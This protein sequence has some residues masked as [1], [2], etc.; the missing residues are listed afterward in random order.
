[1]IP[2]SFK[3][4]GFILLFSTALCNKLSAQSRV[5]KRDSLVLKISRGSGEYAGHRIDTVLKDQ[6]VVLYNDISCQ[7]CLRGG[8]GLEGPFLLVSN[9]TGK[10]MKDRIRTLIL[11]KEF[12]Q[13]VYLTNQAC[14]PLEAQ[15]RFCF[16]EDIGPLRME[17][18][19]LVLW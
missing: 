1:M 12:A 9:Q 13:K 6:K 7:K 5:F 17:V 15:L 8:E 14:V 16:A 3:G 18:K 11:E 10:E 2:G 19:N 4:L